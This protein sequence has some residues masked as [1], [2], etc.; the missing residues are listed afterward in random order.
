MSASPPGGGEI[1]APATRFTPAITVEERRVVSFDGTDLAYH[2]VGDGPP[3]LLANGL[4][5]SW[6]AWT[7]QLR[8]FQDRYRFL[9]WD[10]RGL[11][12]SGAPPD[13]GALDVPANARDALAVLDAEGVE[14]VAVWG[15]SMGVQVALELWRRAPDRIASFVLIN[16]VAGKPWE[17]IASVPHVGRLAPFVLRTLRGMPELVAGAT[18]RA[19]AWRGT[20]GMIKRLGLASATLDVEMF[21]D[22]AGSFGD[23]DMGIYVHTL[24]QIGEHDAHDVLPTIRVPLLMLAGGRDL[25]TPRTAAERIAREVP[26]AELLVVPGGTHYLAVEYPELVN[27]RIERF[28]RDRGWPPK[29]GT[30][31]RRSSRPPPRGWR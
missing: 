3:I 19:V 21:A 16:G 13:R 22:L 17:T 18:R 27:L 24:E 25:M 23:L 14:K 10:Q 15:W 7:Y 20:P 26:G 1:H 12:R 6:K 4:G 29:G 30:G 11:Y 9:S 31:A 5:G 8:H 28:L 2:L